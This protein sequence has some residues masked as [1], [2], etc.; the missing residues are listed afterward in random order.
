MADVICRRAEFQDAVGLTDLI[1]DCFREKILPFGLS[2]DSSS[3]FASTVNRLAN[4]PSFGAFVADCQGKLI[5][6]CLA[7][8]HPSRFAS[9]Q[10]TGCEVGWWVSPEN[11]NGRT[12]IRL[13]ELAEEWMLEQGAQLLCFMS[14]AGSHQGM[15]RFY[16]RRG[17][18]PLE[19]HYMKV[20]RHGN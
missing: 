19:T 7:E 8:I 10:K 20:V 15:D 17:Y 6:Y 4:D 16:R 14:L 2:A 1:M 13:Q 18:L 12:A 5:G 9:W 3:V 11:R